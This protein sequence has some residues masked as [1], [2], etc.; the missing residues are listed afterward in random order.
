MAY[1]LTIH[2]L[3]AVVWVG[4]MFFALLVLRPAVGPLEPAVRL[5]LWRRV[6][7]RFFRPWASPCWRCSRPGTR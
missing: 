2:V 7:A 4:G 5:A 1:L 6:F 3:S